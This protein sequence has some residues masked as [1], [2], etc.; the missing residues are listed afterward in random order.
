MY[1]QSV[2]PQSGGLFGPNYGNQNIHFN[3]HG[4]GQGGSLFNREN[5]G[6]M[7]PSLGGPLSSAVPLIE[8]SSR[9]HDI[10]FGGES[11]FVTAD[12]L[13]VV[14]G[15]K[16]FLGT[17]GTGEHHEDYDL[18]MPIDDDHTYFV[19][20]GEDYSD[21]PDTMEDLF[22]GNRSARLVLR[23]KKA[24]PILYVLD[25]GKIKDESIDRILYH[26]L[27]FAKHFGHKYFFM[28]VEESG[29]LAPGEPEVCH[30]NHKA[31]LFRKTNYQ[32]FFNEFPPEEW[33]LEKA[34]S[35]EKFIVTAPTTNNS[36]GFNMS[37]A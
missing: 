17:V 24:A 7:V 30:L 25:K 31:G 4:A 19:D 3:F 22:T 28:I 14:C 5:N 33:A 16:P 2:T 18:L 11:L 9:S 35:K 26:T 36:S 29:G 32:I 6:S 12:D 15:S 20:H 34:V 13:T 1:Q 37:R 27:F 10:L 21:E 8:S 23:D